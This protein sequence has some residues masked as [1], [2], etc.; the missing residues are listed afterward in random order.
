MEYAK[1]DTKAAG[2][3]ITCVGIAPAAHIINHQHAARDTYANV[4]HHNTA[5]KQKNE[6]AKH[7]D[8]TPRR[9]TKERA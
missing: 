4:K 9:H 8:W 5:A 6:R 1:G 2:M 7:E 3:M